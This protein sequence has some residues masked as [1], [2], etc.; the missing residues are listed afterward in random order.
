MKLKS[1][2]VYLKK[3]KIFINILLK[4][5]SEHTPQKIKKVSDNHILIGT[6]RIFID[7]NILRTNK[8]TIRY[9]N[10]KELVMGLNEVLELKNTESIKSIINRYQNLQT[11]KIYKNGITK[12]KN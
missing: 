10:I 12:R 7:N 9:R 1:I 6:N 11:T 8:T 3:M 2:H 5:I 4:S